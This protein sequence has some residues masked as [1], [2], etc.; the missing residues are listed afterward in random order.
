MTHPHL[1]PDWVPRM[2]CDRRRQAVVGLTAHASPA[3]APSLA[4]MAASM[5]YM[6][7]VM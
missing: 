7:A 2:V 4:V 3:V 5:A 6:L 1:L